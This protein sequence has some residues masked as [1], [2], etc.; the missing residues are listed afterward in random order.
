MIGNRLRQRQ[1]G[2]AL[3]E[4]AMVATCMLTTLFGALEICHIALAYSCMATAARAATRYAIVHG[5]D[6]SG[7]GVDGP[8][9]SNSSSQVQTAAVNYASAAG[10]SSL[11]ATNVIVSYTVSGNNV[12]AS[13]PYAN[14]PGDIVTV[15]ISYRYQP[16]ATFLPLPAFIM[17]TQ[18][19][20]TICF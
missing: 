10:L 7:T 3:V 4:F 19:E 18:S 6:R 14:L 16:L 8:S 12:A 13:D 17:N 2:A 15:T 9:G 11:V 5:Y 1:K 20:G